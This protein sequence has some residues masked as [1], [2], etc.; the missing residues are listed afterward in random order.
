[1]PFQACRPP[2]VLLPGLRLMET[3]RGAGRRLFLA[4]ESLFN[5]V[6]GDRLNPF[7]RLGE[8]TFLLF[9]IA[10]ASG[11]YLYAFFRTSV[12][13][14]HAS[15]RALEEIQ[16]WAGGVLRSM[17][18]YASDAMVVTML[19]HLLRH[20]CFDR[21][22]GYRWFSWISG[23]AVLW[24]TYSSGINGFMLPWDSLAQFT[25]VATTEFLDG[26]PLFS[27]QLA[28]NFI[29]DA[30]VSDRLFSL[31]SFLHIGIPL[32]LLLL[33][34]V[35]I[36]RV[37]RARS[38]P[39][40]SIAVPLIFSLVVL[41]W[42]QPV[43]STAAAALSHLPDILPFDWFYLA[44]FPVMYSY[45][46]PAAWAML[47]GGTL[48]L[49]LLPWLPPRRGRGGWR[50]VFHPGGG[51]VVVKS[52][53]TLLDAALRESIPVRYECR[54]GGCGACRA[55]IVAGRADAGAYQAAA[56]SASDAELGWVL[57]CC[58][59]P[60]TDCDVEFEPAEGS[61]TARR[62]QVTV[63]SLERAAPDVMVVTLALP[64]GAAIPFRAGQYFNVI[65]D[66]GARRPFSFA[67][68]PG[69]C[70]DIEMHVRLVPG[71]RFTT[72]VFTTLEAGD[73]LDIEGPFGQFT[74]TGSDRPI[75][76]IAGATG[77]APV[78]SI[79]E[80]ALR[81]GVNRTMELY[82]GARRPADLYRADLA[83]S[84]ES[85][86]PNVR[87][88]P[89]LSEPHTG[90]GWT[91]RTGLVAEAVVADHPDLTGYEVYA[92]GSTLMVDASR[93]ALLA[94]GLPEGACFSD[95]FVTSPRT[96]DPA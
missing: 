42:V 70:T 1:M 91:G 50:V 72:H 56:L 25:V 20:F 88:V 33:L 96:H 63:K 81:R 53:E 57:A 78:K 66:D 77:F 18:R 85:D 74:L 68:A 28:R 51:A 6:F 59:R 92:C 55:R 52:G 34:W 82:W 93:S 79:I 30:A 87:F 37:P 58:A 43:P 62:L 45:G 4:V 44:T 64:P 73:R 83:R 16:P 48:L 17:H 71:G 19:L 90:D 95:A 41:A 67:S 31:L 76:F 22:R 40:A 36:Q 60:L 21:Y 75:V 38:V 89:V 27:G 80:D 35:H 24:L 69:I 2:R 86:H 14:A 13:E 12:H 29:A 5:S 7:Y 46:I 65:L 54:G 15:V 61:S 39:P 84:W 49:A 3:I 11:V 47:A 26:S 23:V 9:W 94:R 32:V 10:V 8:I